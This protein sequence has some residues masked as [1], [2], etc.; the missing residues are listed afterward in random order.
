MEDKNSEYIW[1]EICNKRLII[2]GTGQIGKLFF[3][4]YR[5]K[6]SIYACTC[7]D[8]AGQPLEGL[9]FVPSDEINVD[10]DFVVICSGAYEDI[11]FYLMQKGWHVNQNFITYRVF[12]ALYE[13]KFFQKKII[14]AIGQCEVREMTDVLQKLVIFSQKYSTLY[15]DERKVCEHGDKRQLSEAIEC[16][17]ILR[18][19]DYFIRPSSLNPY[20]ALSYKHLQEKINENCH[21]CV[22]SLFHF[23][24]Y[25][26]QDISKERQIAKYYMAKPKEKICAYIESDRV[27]DQLIE[28]GLSCREIIQRIESDCVI[29][30]EII[31]ANH[32]RNIK[33]IKLTDRLSDI[34]AADFIEEKYA[35]NKLFC[36][37]G[38]FNATLLKEYVRRLLLLLE[39]QECCKELEQLNINYIYEKINEFPIY[40]Y[41]AKILKLQWIDEDT[42]YRMILPSGIKYVTFREYME[43]LVEYRLKV[44]EVLVLC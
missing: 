21:I 27:I 19:A 10:T 40:P 13:K 22:I 35:V 43:F 9:Q 32:I 18:V 30:K 7:T 8:N 25:W 6:F 15:Y 33:R 20:S 37:R 4:K 2:Y 42:K 34:K 36:D 12:S 38:H 14:V 1:K 29:D 16:A 24:S 3:D 39:E 41:T 11:S 5:N 26:P 44:K 23:D 31:L 17:E 28:N